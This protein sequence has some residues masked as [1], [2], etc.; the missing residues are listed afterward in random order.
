M[1]TS[2]THNV[3][4]GMGE[5]SSTT[6]RAHMIPNDVITA[7][8]AIYKGEEDHVISCDLMLSL[9]MYGDNDGTIPA[10]FQI[11]YLIGWKPDQSQVII[12]WYYSLR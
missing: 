9:E 11:L 10:T 8:S 7:A 3:I 4:S 2:N 12:L 6:H 5:N 1:S